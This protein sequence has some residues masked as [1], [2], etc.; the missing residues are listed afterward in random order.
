MLKSLI[1]KNAED[2]VETVTKEG[3]RIFD[4][5]ASVDPP[6][7]WPDRTRK[8]LNE[9]TKLQGV[10]AATASLLLS[11][12]QPN[13]VPF[14]SD[15][16]YKWCFWEEGT[17]KGWDR[18]LKYT[19]QEYAR[20]C[21]RVDTFKTRWQGGDTL[22]VDDDSGVSA[23]NIEKVAY[24]LGKQFEALNPTVPKKRKQATKKEMDER[25]ALVRKRCEPFA[26]SILGDDH[27]N[28]TSDESEQP[29]EEESSSR[30]RRRRKANGP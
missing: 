8:A 11:T 29:E 26:R 28:E 5:L 18:V 13:D 1:K 25:R 15:E 27:Y 19:A 6:P 10:G 2:T 7:R 23:L 16:L 3:F 22:F 12:Y 4:A 20:L 21:D 9:L 30:P 17:G 24:T 14:F